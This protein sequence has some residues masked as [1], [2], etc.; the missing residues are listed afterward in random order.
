[1]RVGTAP[2]WVNAS[3]TTDAV[4]AHLQTD[5]VCFIGVSSSRVIPGLGMQPGPGRKPRLTEQER[6]KI[7]VLIK[8]PPPGRS[9]RRAAEQAVPVA[10][11]IAR[12][13]GGSIVSVTAQIF[14]F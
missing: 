2:L 14:W 9:E 12:A 1:M 3:P 10:A 4:S 8:Q 11:R 6:S 13:C 5:L 7:L